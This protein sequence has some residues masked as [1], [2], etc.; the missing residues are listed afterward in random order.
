MSQTNVPNP[1]SFLFVPKR[2]SKSYVL[3]VYPLP[4]SYVLKSMSYVLFPMSPNV[5][6]MSYALCSMSYVLCLMP[7]VPVLCPMSCV[8][9]PMSGSVHKYGKYL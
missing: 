7:Y 1:M 3:H 6:P 2:I 9:C 8:L 4:M 5:C